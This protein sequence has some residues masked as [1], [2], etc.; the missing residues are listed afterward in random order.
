MTSEIDRKAFTSYL[1]QLADRVDS[2]EEIKLSVLVDARGRSAMYNYGHKSIGEMFLQLSDQLFVQR[3]AHL[4]PQLL[5]QAIEQVNDQ[6]A[7][8]GS[9]H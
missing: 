8:R 4:L 1:R 3:M 6:P 9:T 5:P 7:T 2:G